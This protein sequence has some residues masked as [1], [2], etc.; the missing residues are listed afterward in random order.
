MDTVKMNQ[1]MP[2][3]NKCPQCGTPLPAGALAGLCPACLLKMG[4]ADD[5]V[6]DA[7]QPP[8]NPP[9]VAELAAKFP[10]LEILE[11]I[12][13]GG[14][15]AVYKA[16]Q[17]ELDRI[18]ALKIL[19]PGIGDD[20]AFAERFAREAKALAKLNHP[21]I[22]TLYE[23]GR[24]DLPVSQTD[25]AAQQ[26]HPTGQLYFFLMEFVDGVNLRQLLRTGRISPREALAIVPQICDALQFAHDQGIV[27]RDIKPE[28]ILLDRRGRVK[29]ADFGLAKI[30]EGKR[31]AEH[32]SAQELEGDHPA[33]QCSALLTDAGKIMGTPQYMSPEQK[34]HPEAVDHRAD[35]YALGVV[36]YQMLTGE[37]PGKKI[38]P[39]S[40]KVQIDVRLDEVVLRALEKNPELRYQQAS[41]LK[42]Q[43][44]TISLTSGNSAQAQKT[45]SNFR[46]ALR[47]AIML[48]AGVAL[49][50]VIY[51]N[52]LPQTYSATA[53]LKI[54]YLVS[55][56]SSPLTFHS[57]EPASIA[58]EAPQ[59]L[60]LI[61]S[62]EIIL[63]PVITKLDLNNRW[64]KKYYGGQ[65]LKE[66]ET[67]GI[68]Q[69]RLSVTPI[70]NTQLLAITCYDNAPAEA[71]EIANA[72]AESYKSYCQQK[73]QDYVDAEKQNH[74]AKSNQD[75]NIMGDG[76]I[77]RQIQ[78]TDIAEPPDHPVRPNKVLIVASGIVIGL[79]LA[80]AAFVFRM[81]W[82]YFR[83][84]T[85]L[86]DDE[87][88]KPDRFWRWF[89]VAVL[90]IIAIPFFISIIGLLAAIA[91]P[92]FVKA[93]QI[94]QQNA[95]RQWTQQ[96]WQLWQS[97]KLA[98]AETK[99][100][101]AVQLVPDD[102]DAWNGLGWAQFNAGNNAAAETSF[103]KAIAVET[104]QPGALNG[105]G[106]IYLS[107]RKFGDAEKFLLQAAPNA[108]AAW[109]GLARLY[110]LE[111]KFEPAEIWA[112]KIVDSGQADETAKKMFEAAKAKKLSDG[113]RLVIEPPAPQLNKL[114][115]KSD[116]AS[117]G[118][119]IER[120]I[121]PNNASRRAFNLGFGKF[122]EPEP[123]RALDFSSGGTNSLR[124]AGVDL[125]A[126]DG[127]PLGELST[128]DMRL[129]GSV[130]AATNE[131]PLTFDGITADQA[132][133]MA[134]SNE[135][136]RF[137][138]DNPLRNILWRPVLRIVDTNLYL[139]ITRND[140]TGVLQIVRV[141]PGGVKIRYKLVQNGKQ[142]QIDAATG[143]PAGTEFDGSS[144]AVK[145]S[146]EAWSP[147]LAPDEKPDLQKILNSAKSLTDEGSYEDALQHYLWYFDHS[148]NDA[149]QKGVR[150]SFAL[151]DWIELGR[152]YPK[153][154]QAL[155][156]IRDA[157]ARQFSTG[158]GYFDLFQEIAGINQYLNDTAA[159]LTLFQSIE[160][161]DP[162][163]AG[164]CYPLVQ[165]LL[166]QK[167]EYEKCLGYIGDP[168]SAFDRIR[169]SR[170][171][172]KKWEDQQ[173][174]RREQ[175]KE[176]FQAMAKTN[177]AFAHL[178]DFPVPPP[179]ADNN[180]V[181]QTRELIEVLVGAGHQA[182]AEKIRDQALAVLDDARL[183]SAVS[184][185]EKKIRDG[186]SGNQADHAAGMKQ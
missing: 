6:T 72:V 163:L 116:S 150:L 37:L 82:Y 22:V 115:A 100:Q 16:R 139:F 99:F 30:V 185:A 43:V 49:L 10:Q 97:G 101:K 79:F 73:L 74:A 168:E 155:V 180:F 129:C 159:T 2:D 57:L 91:I 140:V 5:T 135:Q 133:K 103:Q 112:Q 122:I 58:Y 148:R 144:N 166:V 12:G 127:R 95:A 179:F 89:A 146:N 106:Q 24:A 153:A 109:F 21:G 67:L 13:K 149:G 111:G 18:V 38:E 46:S 86:P 104:N 51:A 107:Q 126:E 130:S 44:E 142:V 119:V 81:V 93:R 114:L 161:G 28:N 61:Q 175:E 56:S 34:E 156:E 40:S 158:T 3:G 4:A 172:M 32:R 132:Q 65:K 117:F 25:E 173:A 96:G 54:D 14:M 1:P 29:V 33:G 80:G 85:R 165:G 76:K 62:S 120:V 174:S 184:E 186:D 178:P 90:A 113:L 71:P 154:K 152:R 59:D 128:L 147:T 138:N 66:T 27:H 60:Y 110:L 118:P 134:A 15:G 63:K 20:P 36:F 131:P 171:R 47:W 77:F 169:D 83:K 31:S 9:P 121:E 160:H 55:S 50:S 26:R 164:Q 136:W 64:G 143:L 94:S 123:G 75:Y 42:T 151:S 125:Y 88:K 17:K 19:P 84:K 52:L 176:R 162:Q 157:D 70:K 137:R 11:L 48:F 124:A 167:G 69:S 108:P 177:P 41:V 183:K 35:I 141:D 78:I 181:G 105:L 39:P 98:E 170:E 102:A 23:F 53:R 7:K 145:Q 92:N 8:F 45:S 68:L 182:D 87:K